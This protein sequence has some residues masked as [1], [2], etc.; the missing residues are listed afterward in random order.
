[1]LNMGRGL[2]AVL[3]FTWWKVPAGMTRSSVGLDEGVCEFSAN[4]K[5][6]VEDE[7]FS[8]EYFSERDFL[9]WK[10]FVRGNSSV[11]LNG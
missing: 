8:A 5:G 4:L 6:V 11:E 10:G 2:L 1:M 9:Q 7:S 3:F